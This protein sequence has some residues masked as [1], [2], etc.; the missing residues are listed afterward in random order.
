MIRLCVLI[1]FIALFDST[2]E[3]SRADA[4]QP[5]RA[6]HAEADPSPTPSDDAHELLDSILETLGDNPDQVPDPATRELAQDRYDK[7]YQ[8]ADLTPTQQQALSKLGEILGRRESPAKTGAS[9]RVQDPEV[10]GPQKNDPIPAKDPLEAAYTK[11]AEMLAK[12]VNTSSPQA[13]SYIQKADQHSKNADEHYQRG[14]IAEGDAETKKGAEAAGKAVQELTQLEAARQAAIIQ[15]AILNGKAPSPALAPTDFNAAVFVG[16]DDRIPQVT[17]VAQT[18]LSGFAGAFSQGATA[19]AVE[20]AGLNS[21]QENYEN[22]RNRQLDTAMGLLGAGASPFGGM[23]V[24]ATAAANKAPGYVGD[25]ANPKALAEE[26][27]NLPKNINRISFDWHGGPDGTFTISGKQYT[28]GSPEM[29]PVW[30]AIRARPDTTIELN[31]CYGSTCGQ[32]VADK[33]GAVVQAGN[34]TMVVHPNGRVTT[35]PGGTILRFNPRPS[36]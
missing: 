27:S 15:A 8:A 26:I 25:A 22:L 34:T 28:P 6:Q 23:T 2:I 21:L 16:R 33:T 12:P 5:E 4:D 18:V 9:A 19:N 11:L 17:A 31:Q 20:Q 13:A 7:L 30:D 29:A 32:A 24:A 10:K 3:S 36:K 35:L 1:I 14:R